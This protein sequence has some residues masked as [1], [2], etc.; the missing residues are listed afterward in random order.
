[1]LERWREESFDLLKELSAITSLTH[2]RLLRL[3]VESRGELDLSHT[4]WTPS[5]RRKLLKWSE[6]FDWLDRGPDNAPTLSVAPEFFAVLAEALSDV[7]RRLPK[8][9]STQ[10]LSYE[11]EALQVLLAEM[12]KRGSVRLLAEFTKSDQAILLA[13]HDQDDTEFFAIEEWRACPI[14]ETRLGPVVRL[15][16]AF[17]TRRVAPK[18]AKWLGPNYDLLLGALSCLGLAKRGELNF[19]IDLSLKKSIE[20]QIFKPGEQTQLAFPIPEV[21]TV[22]LILAALERA[23][24]IKREGRGAVLINETPLQNTDDLLSLLHHFAGVLDLPSSHQGIAPI[25]NHS[26]RFLFNHNGSLF[27]TEALEV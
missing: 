3:L 10:K 13:A 27:L 20:R 5:E 17:L 4:D 7:P 9:R 23:K 8:S 25:C 19:R 15:K 1:M 14:E 6:A 21:P 24:F 18:V 11:N 22:K 26:L 2:R 16:T 12:A